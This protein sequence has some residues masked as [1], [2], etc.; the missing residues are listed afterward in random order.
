MTVTKDITRLENSSVKLSITVGKDDIRSEYDELISNYT[1]SIQIPGFRKGK[2]PKE[3][4]IRKFADALKEEAL[5]KIMEKSVE[6]VFGDET[7]LKENKPLPYSTPKVQDE[8]KLDLENDL[9]FSVVYDVL[10]DVKVGEWQGIEAVIPDISISDEDINRELEGIRE[11][12]SIVLDKNEGESAVSGDIVTVNYCELNDSGEALAG[13]EREDYTFTL[14]SL[15]NAYKFDNE[16]VG[17]KKGETKEFQKSFPDPENYE[18][19]TK[20]LKV[21]I[22][23][24]KTKTLPDLDDDLAQDVDEKYKTLEDLKNSIRDRL[25]NDLERRLKEIKSSKI[26]EKIMDNTPVEIP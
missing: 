1:K 12:N 8:P 14:G 15:N 18:E 24:L 3:V 7:F 13:T 10:P 11:R 9:S 26:L 25:N 4:F 6:L 22:T 23:A 21:T 20:K 16:L 5:G 19:V 17:M 2:V